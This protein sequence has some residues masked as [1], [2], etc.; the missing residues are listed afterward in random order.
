MCLLRWGTLPSLHTHTHT[1][2]V[3]LA[4]KQF[5]RRVTAGLGVVQ[6]APDDTERLRLEKLHFKTMA[7][8]NRR[9]MQLLNSYNAPPGPPAGIHRCGFQVGLCGC[10]CIMMPVFV[11]VFVAVWPWP[12]L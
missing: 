5:V 8:H 2:L 11:A 3:P 4:S 6:E 12:W 7:D 10:L 9:L 1:P